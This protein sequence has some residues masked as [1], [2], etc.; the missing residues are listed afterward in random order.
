[1]I[2]SKITPAQVAATLE[3]SKVNF[4]FIGNRT[5][6]EVYSTEVQKALKRNNYIGDNRFTSAWEL[7][8]SIR[9][10]RADIVILE[11]EP[12]ETELQTLIYPL[13]SASI[14][15]TIRAKGVYIA[16][17]PEKP[18]TLEERV[19]ILEQLVAEGQKLKL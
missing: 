11:E 10:L 16:H 13:I 15:N 2:Y 9:G 17:I 12:T 4:L 18:K 1:M 6:C 19:A 3:E 8:N 14:G 5:L 7:N